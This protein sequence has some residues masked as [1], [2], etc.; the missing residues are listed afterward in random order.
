METTTKAN[1]KR[2]QVTTS[3]RV[4]DDILDDPNVPF[5]LKKRA[6]L[7]SLFDAGD[8]KTLVNRMRDEVRYQEALDTGKHIPKSM[9]VAVSRDLTGPVIGHTAPIIESSGHMSEESLDDL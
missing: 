2:G 1:A 5:N 4:Q 7:S 9:H 8:M 6:I 3:K